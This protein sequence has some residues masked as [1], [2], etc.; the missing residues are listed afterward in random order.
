MDRAMRK[1]FRPAPLIAAALAAGTL[2]GCGESRLAGSLL[3]M[4]P[5]KIGEFDCTELK[6]RL[7]GA[8]ARLQ[9]LEQLRDKTNTSTAGPVINSLVYGPDYSKARWE[10]QLYEDETARKNCDAP[11]PPPPGP[12]SLE[13]GR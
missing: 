1:R 6:K 3:Y 8:K 11:P 7:N 4:A 2:A 9:D 13:P 10:Y 12:L 5:N